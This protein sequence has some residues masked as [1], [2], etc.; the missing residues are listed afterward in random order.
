ME[1]SFD[2]KNYIN[3]LGKELVEEF[4]KSNTTTHPGAV[5]SA[6]EKAVIGKIRCL[7]PQNMDV[8]SGFVID[9]FGHT[10]TQCDIIIY[11]KTSLRFIINGDEQNTYFPCES[12]VAIGEV[13][14]NVSTNEI[15]D[16]FKKLNSI[17]ILKRYTQN[18]CEFR[19]YGNNLTILDAE[20]HTGG[21][22]RI[23][24]FLICSDFK[25]TPETYLRKE[26]MLPMKVKPN[27][28]V[29]LE[30]YSIIFGKDTAMQYCFDEANIRIIFESENNA[31][32]LL[33]SGIL[34]HIQRGTTTP[35]CKERYL[36]EEGK[37]IKMIGA[38]QIK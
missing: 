23:F 37:K 38:C 30:S 35:E 20:E 16:F 10:S 24:T 9:S 26:L 25:V 14:S 32:P 2:S 21:L 31:F 22:S 15:D 33:I 7:L 29:S 5:G 13:K 17:S 36:M 4:K 12:V 27:M 3:T 1:A 19:H 11:E 8:G 18:K 34:S 28:V 6:K